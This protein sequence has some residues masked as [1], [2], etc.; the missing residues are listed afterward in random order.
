MVIMLLI[1]IRKDMA[2][3][4]GVGQRYMVMEEVEDS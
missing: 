4:I 1:T 2:L 3:V